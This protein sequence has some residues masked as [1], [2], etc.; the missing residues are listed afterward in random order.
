MAFLGMAPLEACLPICSGDAGHSVRRFIM[1]GCVA[2][3]RIG[4][5]CIA[6]PFAPS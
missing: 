2:G 3:Q 6:T 1:N 4:I 5:L